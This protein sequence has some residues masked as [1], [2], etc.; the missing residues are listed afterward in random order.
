MRRCRIK[1]LIGQKC[2]RFLDSVRSTYM[3]SLQT[4]SL[5]N[6]NDIF[7]NNIAN[8]LLNSCYLERIVDMN[9]IW[10]NYYKKNKYKFMSA[11]D[12]YDSVKVII[13]KFL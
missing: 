6:S 7:I 4:H 2:H 8:E 5:I 10:I 3:T 11:D 13:D 12:T 9:K 1:T